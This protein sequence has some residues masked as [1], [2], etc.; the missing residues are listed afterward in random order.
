MAAIVIIN[1]AVA[2]IISY[3]CLKGLS[4]GFTVWSL[5]VN[6]LI[7][8]I[9]LAVSAI[10]VWKNADDPSILRFLA[11]LMLI[12]GILLMILAIVMKIPRKFTTDNWRNLGIILEIVSI[13]AMMTLW[14]RPVTWTE[15]IVPELAVIA[16]LW[17]LITNRK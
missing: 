2:L 9:V 13:I 17:L 16:G 6:F 1:V 11:S 7:G 14:Q 4:Q 8:G 12:V 3:F 15:I 5:G 10:P